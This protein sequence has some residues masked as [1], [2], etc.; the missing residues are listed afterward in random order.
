M[1]IQYIV[2]CK[3]DSTRIIYST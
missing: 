3:L 1:N 2:M